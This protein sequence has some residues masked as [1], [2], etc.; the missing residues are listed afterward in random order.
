MAGGLGRTET[1]ALSSTLGVVLFFVLL[2]VATFCY[3]KYDILKR[4]KRGSSIESGKKLVYV[5]QEKP[6]TAQSGPPSH[7]GLQRILRGSRPPP[8]QVL[9]NPPHKP[10][11]HVTTRRLRPPR[12]VQIHN[13]YPGGVRVVRF[14]QDQTKPTLVYRPGPPRPTYTQNPHPNTVPHLRLGDYRPKVVN[15][16]FSPYNI[17]NMMEDSSRNTDTS[18][19]SSGSR[20]TW[21][22]AEPEKVQFIQLDEKGTQ[23]K[24]EK[25]RH[26]VTRNS[27]TST[28]GLK[29]PDPPHRKCL[30]W[31]TDL[32]NS[33]TTQYI[34]TN[35]QFVIVDYIDP[36]NTK[37][38][39]LPLSTSTPRNN[40]G[41]TTDSNHNLLPRQRKP[42]EGSLEKIPIS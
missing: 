3:R 14:G 35:G 11:P 24:S 1:I 40:S 6:N 17:R 10:A 8:K 26:R 39:E 31:N 29:S 33:H 38:G 34:E 4:T 21:F 2:G 30:R 37:H 7:S 5:Q 19:N 27:A 25:K 20:F 9:R 18:L 12:E 28:S 22:P 32:P 15:G 13:S 16:Y 36:D 42:H 41:E 23:T